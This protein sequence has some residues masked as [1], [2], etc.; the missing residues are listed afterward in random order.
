MRYI[1]PLLMVLCLSSCGEGDETVITPI[2]PTEV[3]TTAARYSDDFKERS[4]A[5]TEELRKY[6]ELKDKFPGAAREA[7]IRFQGYSVFGGRLITVNLQLLT[8][9]RERMSAPVYPR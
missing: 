9:P 4:K 7:F 2:D 6:M 1:I 3:A 8:H 5:A